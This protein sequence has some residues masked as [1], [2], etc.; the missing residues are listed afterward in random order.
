[1]WLLFWGMGRRCAD[2]D[3]GHWHLDEVVVKFGGRRMSAGEVGDFK[4]LAGFD[5]SADLSGGRHPGPS[6][7]PDVGA[8]P[9][10]SA[11][12]EILTA[13]RILAGFIRRT[14][15]IPTGAIAIVLL[16]SEATEADLRAEQLW[17]EPLA[18][19][20]RLY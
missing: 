11:V 15:R 17:A 3:A 20:H 9:E 5:K 2:S 1:M 6:R 13:G 12:R 8:R 10:Q 14:G 18:G 7:R 16:K 19:G 4:R